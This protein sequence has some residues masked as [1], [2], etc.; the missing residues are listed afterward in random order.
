MVIEFLS[1]EGCP[2]APVLRQRLHEALH[3]LGVTVVPIAV[4]LGRLC[5]ANDHRSGFGSPTIL[6]DGLDLFGMETP[7]SKEEPACRIYRPALPST[8][9]ILERLRGC[10]PAGL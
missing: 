3:A 4:D 10:V 9:D 7:A 1:F 2:H 6:L 8:A 5:R